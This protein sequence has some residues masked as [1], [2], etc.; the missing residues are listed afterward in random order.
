MKTTTHTTRPS[1]TAPRPPNDTPWMRLIAVARQAPVPPTDI[2]LPPGFAT[3]VVAL[4]F[5]SAPRFVT[6][7]GGALLIWFD[8]LAWRALGVASL[9][10][11]VCVLWSVA[12]NAATAGASHDTHLNDYLDPVGEVLAVVEPSS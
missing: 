10:M 7:P 5:A 1:S 2:S 4:A 6:G 12:P 9:A 3:R 8:R 11:T